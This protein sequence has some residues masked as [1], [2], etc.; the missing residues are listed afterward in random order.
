MKLQIIKNKNPKETPKIKLKIDKI[1]NDIILDE[2][3]TIKGV[4]KIA[5]EYK[6][7]NRSAI[8]WILN[9]Y[10]EKNY[11]KNTLKKYPNKRILNNKFNNYK[12]ADY[13]KDVIDLIKRVTTVSVKTMK[14]IEQMKK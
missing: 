10:K 1:N 13:K 2:N 5:F 12:F 14:I 6:L 4:P 3:T 11:S 9:Q 7:G 8:E